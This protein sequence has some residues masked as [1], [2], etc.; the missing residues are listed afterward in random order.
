MRL[1]FVSLIV[2]AASAAPLAAQSVEAGYVGAIAD[3]RLVGTVGGAS[4][5]LVVPTPV[6][7]LQLVAGAEHLSG[8]EHPAAFSC[9]QPTGARYVFGSALAPGCTRV[10][11]SDASAITMGSI[12]PR[13]SLLRFSRVELAGFATARVGFARVER[14]AE[15]SGRYVDGTDGIYGGDVGAMARWQPF[16]RT[17]FALTASFSTGAIHPFGHGGSVDQERDPITNGMRIDRWQVGFA[18]R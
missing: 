2:A 18:W 16:A 17:P 14:S 1:S 8:T 9:E 6:R 10:A 13:I 5:Q 3:T 7:R 4:L 11:A 15:L 12:G